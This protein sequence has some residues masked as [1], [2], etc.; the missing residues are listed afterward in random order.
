MAF[1]VFIFS[2]VRIRNIGGI[3]VVLWVMIGLLAFFTFRRTTQQSTNGISAN[4]ALFAYPNIKPADTV[5][6]R[7]VFEGFLMVVVASLLL[8]GAALFDHGAM[9]A[10]PLLFWVA[11]FC[12]W[13][14]GLGFGLMAS[15]AS[16]L[17]P[18]A[19]RV[20]NMAMMPLY[21]VSGVI[22]PLSAVPQPYREWLMFNPIAHGLEAARL[23]YV[24]NYHA[25]PELSLTYLVG[26]ALLSIFLGLA[27][28][29]RFA[30]RLVTQ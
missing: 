23:G 9:P 16:E 5:L 8:A 22:F 6:V 28:H 1:L 7:G 29:R 2:V 18:E 15:V 12:L 24:A 17:I 21:F 10:D 30:L 14:L 20:V 25:P 11:F 3:D 26:C 13:L 4:R 27:L 19:G